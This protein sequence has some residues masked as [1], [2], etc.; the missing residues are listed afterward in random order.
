MIDA[1]N[2]VHDR[3][4]Q[5]AGKVLTET[6]P[7]LVLPAPLPAGPALAGC[8]ARSPRAAQVLA[9]L[10]D[11]PQRRNGLWR[12]ASQQVRLH[13]ADDW[14]GEDRDALWAGV[15]ASVNPDWV[16]SPAEQQRLRRTPDP[17]AIPAD[18]PAICPWHGGP[19][20]SRETCVC[21]DDNG[22]PATPGEAAA[23]AT[24]LGWVSPRPSAWSGRH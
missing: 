22:D 1:L 3:R 14:T 21:T 11:I 5:F 19:W 20:A 9:G 23:D 17:V 18:A 12:F 13:A 10:A 7:E 2:N 8:Q 24:R 15:V 6:D 16:V 4:G